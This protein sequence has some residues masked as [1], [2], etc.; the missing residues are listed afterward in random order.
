MSK[1]TKLDQTD[2]RNLI[3]TLLFFIVL[4]WIFFGIAYAFAL[5]LFWAAVPQIMLVVLIGVSVVVKGFKGLFSR[6]NKQ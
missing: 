4:Q 6:S 5:G 2:S 1:K 3:N